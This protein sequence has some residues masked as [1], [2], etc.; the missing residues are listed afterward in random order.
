MAVERVDVSA[1]YQWDVEALYDSLEAWQ[2]QIEVLQKQEPSLR[3]AD[4]LL[5]RGRLKESAA[6]LADFLVQYLDSQRLLEKLYTYAHLRHD[7]DIAKDVYKQAYAQAINLLHE[8]RQV[9]SWV[10][11]EI[12]AIP[13]TTIDQSQQLAPYRV[14]IEKIIR[15]KPHTLSIREEELMALAAAALE[16]SSRTFSSL[17]NVDIVFPKILDEQGNALELTQGTYQVYVRSQDRV[18]RQNAFQA[19]H[20]SFAAYENTLCELIQGEIRNHIFQA[21]ARKFDS[22]LAAALFPHNINTAVYKNLLATVRAHLPQL[23][24]YM[25]LR[26][27]ILGYKQLHLWDMQV[28]LV[29]DVQYDISY[30]MATDY[31]IESVALLGNAYQ[32]Q[33][34]EGLQKKRWVDRYE[35]ARKRSGAYSSG[36]F[37][38]MPYILMN[39]QGQ[40][41]D[42]M[43]LAHEAGHSMH[44][45]LSWKTQ[46]YHDAQ[47]PIFVAEVASTFNEELLMRLMVK[48]GSKE[49]QRF[50]INQKLNDIRNTFFRQT[51]FAEFELKI[52]ELVEQGIPL[53]PALLKK[54]Y[55]TLNQDYFGSAV[56]IDSEIEIEWARIPHFYYNF[57]VYQYATGIA[58][59]LALVD[60]VEQEGAQKYLAFLSA[61]GSKFPLDLLRDTGA[62]L[63]KPMLI[64]AAI[65]RFSALIDKFEQLS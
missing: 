21:K 15:L 1:E 51:M 45:L 29:P 63:T 17:S 59:A 36:C 23:H 53:T 65:A 16:V 64:E 28:S 24:R 43:T 49:Q 58:A 62:D 10:E 61:G 37:D 41:Q 38:S 40:F 56:V 60:K 54:E 2:R 7:E 18:L 33:L 39:Y 47:Y 35:N 12:L 19:L 20:R 25:D 9:F 27:K 22:S 32:N 34:R 55:Y 11:P 6:T 4:L 48:K 26:K 42:M 50:L 13:T 57:Y 46:A 44:S 8:F 52:H 5:Y 14:F 30:E 31:I 3:W